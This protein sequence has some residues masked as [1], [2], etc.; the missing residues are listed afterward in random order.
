MISNSHLSLIKKLN[1]W[2]KIK[3]DLIILYLITIVAILPSQIENRS[4][5]LVAIAS[6]FI[7]LKYGFHLLENINE[8][9]KYINGEKHL[10]ED[11]LLNYIT[12]Q[13]LLNQ[14]HHQN[15]IT[16]T[17]KYS[18]QSQ[19]SYYQEPQINEAGEV[20][21]YEGLEALDVAPHNQLIKSFNSQQFLEE[22]TGIA[23]LGN[24]GSAKTCLV[25]Y[26]AGELSPN[27]F[28]VL[29]PHADV[30]NPE[31][32]WHG[33]NKIISNYDEILDYL[34]KLLTLLDNKDRQNLV[35]IAD[36][37]PAIRMYAKKQ[38]STIA[39]EFIL[40]YGSEARKFNKLPIFISQ[41]GNTKALG[42]E[43]MGDFLENFAL[44]RLGKIAN[45]YLKYSPNAEIREACKKIAYPMLINE[46]DLYLHPTHGH[47]QK[48]AKHQPPIN[49]K[50]VICEPFN[51]NLNGNLATKAPTTPTIP[52][53]T[54]NRQKLDIDSNVG[55]SQHQDHLS[56]YLDNCFDLD[57]VATNNNKNIC[58]Y[59]QG[60]NIINWS[61][62]TGRKKCKDCNKTFSS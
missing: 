41:S 37:Y 53:S 18:E 38:K 48:V 54:K 4:I 20:A 22:V 35:I 6:G 43:G 50:P 42:L 61:K 29:D 15:L 23:I 58:P 44:I 36:E 19:E 45:K 17:P 31:Y 62:K 56:Q 13:K 26:F 9:E 5:R 11:N 27:Q 60:I 28:L 21:P 52:T 34:E 33:Y 14:Q 49:I 10:N 51:V 7:S 24:S 46:D 30:E 16:S 3:L 25:N 59:C 32:P 8:N 2:N 39:D 12:T 1:F 47:Y 57:Y 40:R 55:E